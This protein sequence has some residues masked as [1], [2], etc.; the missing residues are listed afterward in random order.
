MS[1]SASH[2]TLTEEGENW[3]RHRMFIGGGQSQ[4]LSFSNLTVNNDAWEDLAGISVICYADIAWDI[5]WNTERYHSQKIADGFEDC[6][7]HDYVLGEQHP[8]QK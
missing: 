2:A 1:S 6:I 4:Y 7:R 3:P 8:T 5:A